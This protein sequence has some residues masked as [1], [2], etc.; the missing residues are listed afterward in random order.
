MTKIDLVIDFDGL[1]FDYVRDELS[2]VVHNFFEL[3]FRYSSPRLSFRMA[4]TITIMN[5]QR[6]QLHK[7]LTLIVEIEKVFNKND[8]IMNKRISENEIRLVWGE[9]F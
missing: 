8:F 1:S 4:D 7:V 5:I 3:N 6:I 9:A 2:D